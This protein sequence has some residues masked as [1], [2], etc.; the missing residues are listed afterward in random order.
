M[1]LLGSE[2]Q[3][4]T[5]PPFTN[6]NWSKAYPAFKIAGNLYYVGSYDLAS[7]LLVTPKGNILI[8]TGLDDSY[9][10]IKSSIESLGFSLKDTKVL[11]ITQAHYDHTGALARIKRETGARLLVN[12]SDEDALRTGG[13]SDYEMGKY[14]ET[15]EPVVPDELLKDRSTIKL[16][17]TK[18]KLLSHPGH[19]KGSSSYLVKVKDEDRSYKV[20]I[21]NLPSIII[22]GKFSAVAA[23]P[24]I[25]KDYAY[26]FK[27]MKKL[28]FDLWVASHASQ[29]NLHKL[30]KP[31]DRYDPTIFGDKKAF[32][33][34][35]SDL[36]KAYQE[37]LKDE[38]P[39]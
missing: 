38:G 30:R 11:L 27:A 7:Y 16:G 17:G 1:S 4:Q 19:T 26:T 18:V 12:G 24:D 22:D 23:Y 9:A 5:K 21:A 39:K 20:L 13:K 29:F 36:E 8:N 33:E 34:A 6:P 28:D 37:K 25:Q 32:F 15:F 2:I 14:G 3:A 35:I 10:L 31:D